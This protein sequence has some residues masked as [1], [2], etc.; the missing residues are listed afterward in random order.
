MLQ[1]WQEWA[2]NVNRKT[3][4]AKH[5]YTA[6]DY[7]REL[8][9]MVD[10]DIFVGS[11]AGEQTMWNHFGYRTPIEG[12]YMAGSPTHQGARSPV[13]AATSPVASSR[14]TWVYRCGGNPSTPAP[15]WR[16]WHNVA[17]IPM[18][19]AC[20]DYDRT[21]PLADGRVKPEGIDLTVLPLMMPEPAFR[22]LRHGEFDAA[23]MSLSWYARTVESD[24]RP[25]VALPV[26]PSRMFRHSCI[27]VNSRS[28]IEKPSDLAG[29]RIGCPEYQ[30]TAAVWLKGIMADRH[31]VP[32][33]SVQY[34]T[35]GLEEPGRTEVRM[36]LPEN[37]SV[38]SIPSD[39]TLSDM[40]A[41]GEIDALYTAHMPS[42]FARGDPSVGRLWEDPY[43]VERQYY[44]ETRIFP[45]MHVIVVRQDVYEQRPWVARSLTKA[46]EKAKDLAYRDLKETTALKYMLPWMNKAAE[47]ADRLFGG[48]PFSYGLEDN[49][50]VLETFLRYSN[51]QGLTKRLLRPED[52]F[53]RETLEVSKI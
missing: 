30:M 10:G 1:T 26:F 27:Y 35:G 11:F 53:A 32:V 52:L 14:R 12:L 42:S 41:S 3:I 34:F 43:A 50:D 24:P 51:E 9:N 23:E 17:D 46:F 45:I 31:D 5:V 4:L 8:I 33:D 21:Q 2:P 36:D 15:R 13:A 16:D 44:E 49:R 20:W 37:I 38:H 22:M 48:N 7:S 39:R 25:F 40:L 28:G 47:E 18:T 6:N 29:K 19:L